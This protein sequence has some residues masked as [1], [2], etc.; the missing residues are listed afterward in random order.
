MSD[1]WRRLSKRERGLVILTAL[2]VLVF[3]AKY[4]VITPFLERREW[5]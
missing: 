1:L 2:I 5:V 3:I 4:A